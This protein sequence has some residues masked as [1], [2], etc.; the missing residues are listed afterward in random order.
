PRTG[1]FYR[2][3]LPPDDDAYFENMARTVFQAGLSWQLIADKWSDFKIAFKDFKIDSV[4]DLDEEDIEELLSNSRI[5]RNR[6]KIES[7]LVNAIAFSNVQEEYGSFRNFMDNLDK[8]DNY[9]YAR[10]ELSK[11]FSRMGPKSAMIFLWSI[12]EDIQH[13]E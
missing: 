9:R 7:V 2:D 13:E 3:E 6:A 11:K 4:V 12:G 1:W 5:I 10:K 8:S